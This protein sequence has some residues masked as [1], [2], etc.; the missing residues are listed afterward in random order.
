M[1]VNRTISL[2]NG[3]FD[4]SD[5][6][7][8]IVE[9]FCGIPSL[10]MMICFLFLMGFSK[11]YKNAFYKLVQMDLLIVVY[12]IFTV[13]KIYFSRTFWS[14]QTPCCRSDWNFSRSVFSF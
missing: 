12:F 8:N 3:K 11:V 9:L 13:I 7:V 4:L 10:V 2:E 1:S 5:T 14:T 6:I